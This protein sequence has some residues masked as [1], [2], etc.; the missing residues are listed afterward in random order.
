VNYT[1]NQSFSTFSVSGTITTDGKVGTLASSD[2]TAFTL[3]LTDA[4]GTLTL[5][6]TNAIV[7]QIGS[8]FSATSMGLFYNFGDKDGDLLF[9][10]STDF[11]SDLCFQG[12]GGLCGVGG[13][14]NES[15]SLSN[16]GG[17][18]ATT[19]SMSGVQQFATVTP[20]PEPSSLVLLGTGVVSALGAARRRLLVR[21]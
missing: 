8:D 6:N 3:T 21:A 11:N 12:S 5:S 17:D 2:V 7:Q 13:G 20:T 15:V 9:N 10:N 14:A 18:L 4:S 19:P 1:V 16:S